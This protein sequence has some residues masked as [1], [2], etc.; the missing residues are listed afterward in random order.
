[1]NTCSVG[2][3]EREVSS[4][5]WCA[6]HYG[7]WFKHG[8]VQPNVPIEPR[9]K[10]GTSCLVE[11]CERAVHGRGWCE[12]H[13]QRWFNKGDAA[14]GGPLRRVRG[15]GTVQNGYISV[16]AGGR[17]RLQHRIVMEQILGR[18]LL[19]GEN[20]HHKN[21]TRDDNRPENLELWITR[22]PHGQR[23][24]DMIVWAKEILAR[25]DN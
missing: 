9:M 22:Q 2:T 19:P 11:D 7:R 6:P 13:Y 20:V 25:Y 17:A 5:G 24:P 1:M 18:S 15:T 16:G 8:D 10:R 23:V 4:R 14:A 12:A 3:C 21:G